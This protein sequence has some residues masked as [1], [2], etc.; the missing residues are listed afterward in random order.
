MALLDVYALDDRLLLEL[1]PGFTEKTLQLL[2]K[3]L[4]SEKAYFEAAD[5]AFVVLAVQGPGRGSPGQRSPARARP[6]ASSSTS[7]GHRGEPVRVINGARA[8]SPGLHCWTAPEHGAAV[9]AALA[10]GGRAPVGSRR[11]TCSASR[12]A[13]PGTAGTSTRPVI[14]PETRLEALVNYTKGCYIGQEVVA[15]VKYRGHVNRA[16]SGLVLDGDRVPAA[17]RPRGGRGQGHRARHLRCPLARPWRAHR[18]RL[19]APRA[20]RAGQRGRGRRRRVIVA[21]RVAALPFVE[22]A[23]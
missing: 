21:A 18:A 14:M 15:R 5:D 17:G 20:L 3:Y 22:P 7:S 19:R 12:R 8:A 10:D 13:C 9:W 2:D 11:S 4:I 1:P 23:A 16:L 6:R